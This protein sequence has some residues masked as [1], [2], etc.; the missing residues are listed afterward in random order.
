M[1]DYKPPEETTFTQE[2]EQDTAQEAETIED[3][4]QDAEPASVH[5]EESERSET[6]PL[7]P[8]GPAEPSEEGAPETD[9]PGITTLWRAQ[10]AQ[11]RAEQLRADIRNRITDLE[12]QLSETDTLI[13]ACEDVDDLT[14]LLTRKSAIEL[15]LN[16]TIKQEEEQGQVCTAAAR[17]VEDVQH[18]IAKARWELSA[19]RTHLEH[20]QSKL[21]EA[22]QVVIDL[23]RS[24]IEAER[25]VE[26]ARLHLI[27]LAGSDAPAAP[28]A[29]DE[30]DEQEASDE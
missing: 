20:E 10:Q 2:S 19:A 7:E 13:G 24:I 3:V 8:A 1:W 30:T 6:E 21:A 4:T 23:E 15:L 11:T 14:S 16:R 26:S 12:N 5:T 17:R 9:E 25:D 27:A 28:G 29:D 18:E 22:Q